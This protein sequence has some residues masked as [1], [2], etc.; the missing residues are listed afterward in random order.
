MPVLAVAREH[1]EDLLQ[2]LMALQLVDETRKITKR[3]REILI[4]VVAEPP[5]LLARHGA[6]WETGERLPSR[7]LARTPRDRLDER[8][9]AAG[10]PLATA[11]RRWKRLGDVVILRILPEAQAHGR[12]LAGIYGSVLGAV[13]VVQDVYGVP[14]SMR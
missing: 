5:I 6:R 4:P 9:R 12:A 14:R 3:G 13:T 1:A 2:E 8:L 10:I 11:P 7:S